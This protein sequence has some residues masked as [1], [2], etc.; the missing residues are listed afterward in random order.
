[1][2]PKVP[3]QWTS[4]GLPQGLHDTPE[5]LRAMLRQAL[6]SC[7]AKGSADAQALAGCHRPGIRPVLQRRSGAGEPDTPLV[8]PRT[9]DC[10]A[11]FLGS[12]QRY[13]ELFQDYN[14][15]YWLNNGWIESAFV[16]S[17]QRLEELRREYE[18]RYGE[19]NAAFLMEQDRL[20]TQNYHA[21]AFITSPVYHNPAY[22]QLAR[23]IAEE[24]GW[25]YA[26]FAGDTRML[27][28]LTH[29]DWNEEEFCVCPPY[30][31]LEAAYD[32]RKIQAVPL[33][34]E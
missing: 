5:K 15:A 14:G 1:M 28:M 16:P 2:P 11:Q 6:R 18:E 22:P 20:W 32:G 34:E 24:N 4:P 8:V 30:H 25:K 3:T 33:P 23:Q 21:C 13:L 9:D 10:I 12:Q 19:E 26:E 27:R 31:R 29:G 17:R 7:T